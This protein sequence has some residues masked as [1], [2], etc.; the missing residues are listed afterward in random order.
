[1]AGITRVF[2]GAG[3]PLKRLRKAPMMAVTLILLGLLGFSPRAAGQGLS[4][5]LPGMPQRPGQN[6]QKKNFPPEGP[7][8]FPRTSL[9]QKQAIINDNFKKLKQH[10]QELAKL[11][12]S[13]QNEV[14]KSNQN[15]LSLEIVK[16]A[17]EAEKLA[18]KIKEEAK[19][20]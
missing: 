16:K 9:K 11:A 5:G 18:K 17:E 10:S 3:F 2:A 7:S 8:S 4:Q 15:V 1:M 20:N 13:L 19:G 12:K 14:E 6:S